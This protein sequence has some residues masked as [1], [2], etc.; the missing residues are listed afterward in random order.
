MTSEQ[1]PRET[2]SPQRPL[3]SF[4]S[5]YVRDEHAVLRRRRG[6]LTGAAIAVLSAAGGLLVSVRQPAQ[7]AHAGQPLA[8]A[9]QG[10]RAD[11]PSEPT[12]S[13]PEGAAAALLSSEASA[14]DAFE[15]APFSLA[16]APELSAEEHRLGKAAS[17]H[18]ALTRAGLTRADANA[19]TAALKP[20]LDFTRL[21]PEDTFAI[22]RSPDGSP[23]RVE[24]RISRTQ[25]AVAL[26]DPLGAWRGEKDEHPV[27]T[28]RVVRGGVV[29]SS[30]GDTFAALE[31]HRALLSTF[32]EAFD[33]QIDFS[34]DAQPGDTFRVIYDEVSVDGDAT[35]PG[36]IG[37]EVV[38]IAY[39]GQKV[40]LRQ[41]FWHGQ[42]D[43]NGEFYDARGRALHGGWLRTPVQYDVISSRF[44]MR[45]HPVLQRMQLHNGIDYAASTG[46]PVRAAAHGVVAFAGP[47]G[48]NGNL[49]VLRHA[50]GYETYYAHLSRF[51]PGLRAGSKVSQRQLVAYV[52]NTGRSTGP[53]LHFS[54]KRGERFINPTPQLNGPGLPMPT[55]DL[56]QFNKHV[57]A[58][59]AQLAE[60][61]PQEPVAIAQREP[62]RPPPEELGDEEL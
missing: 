15:T 52:G 20:V 31:L 53:H 23:L 28:T 19:I 12:Q 34:R 32:V 3:P 6:F 4:G 2:H 56:P 30:L 59:S 50:H 47:K 1:P 29:R 9:P 45:F 62:A 39:Q 38:A 13:F 60:I 27:R 5:P 48:L 18:V 22:E 42:D 25:R 7:R 55:K 10:I 8:T 61:T 40:G 17:L 44:G 11:S 58:L 41:A 57:Q 35:M 26:Q 37:A 46:T 51:A 36:Q 14:T 54:L 49:L 16:P 21:R 24:Y 43:R 33:G